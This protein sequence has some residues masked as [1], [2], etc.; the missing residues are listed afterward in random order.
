MKIAIIGADAMARAYAEALD[1][2][3]SPAICAKPD[4]MTLAGLTAAHRALETPA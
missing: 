3:G 2:Q 4:A 1:A